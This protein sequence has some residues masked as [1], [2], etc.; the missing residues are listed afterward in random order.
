MYSVELYNRVRLACHV[1][2]MSGREAARV[3]G[4]DRK[5]VSK[6][7]MHSVPP[8]Y[9]REG[10]PVRPKLDPF[11]PII[12]Q[13]LCKRCFDPTYL[14]YFQGSSWLIVTAGRNLPKTAV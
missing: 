13:I 8:G 6:I 4:I 11:V 1:Q 14:A 12:D 9:R 10:P 2:G 7:L 5:T 3:F